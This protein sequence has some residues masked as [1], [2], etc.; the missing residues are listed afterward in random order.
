IFS[1][2]TF[3]Q[4]VLSLAN[5]LLGSNVFADIEEA[6]SLRQRGWRPRT[7]V[8]ES[9][10]RRAWGQGIGET[11]WDEWVL[12]E[13]KRESEKARKLVERGGGEEARRLERGKAKAN[14]DTVAERDDIE[15]EESTHSKTFVDLPTT[16]PLEEVI[17]AFNNLTKPIQ[18]NTELQT[19]LEDY[20]GEAGSELEP[21]PN[22]SLSTNP[23]FLNNVSSQALRNFTDQVINIWPDLTRSYVG[24]SR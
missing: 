4:D 11:V 10:K 19:F 7:Q 17:A 13:Q 18:N 20:F 24:P 6:T 14:V 21:V 5:E 9:C 15:S 8:C 23:T 2:Y 22:D 3:E 12:R 1:A 16:R